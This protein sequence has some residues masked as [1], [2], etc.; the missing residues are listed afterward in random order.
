M[1][2]SFGDYSERTVKVRIDFLD[3]IKVDKTIKF[4]KQEL[5]SEKL[6]IPKKGFWTNK[7]KQ[8]EICKIKQKR[9]IYEK[10][11]DVNQLVKVFKGKI[12][13]RETFYDQGTKNNSYVIYT[14]V[15]PD[16]AKAQRY[17]KHLKELYP[18]L[19]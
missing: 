12:E 2:K 19:M 9:R 4:W 10:L 14:F 17:R 5:E 13:R 15:F 7:K 11:I 16:S 1:N 6:K 18:E 3:G 8:K